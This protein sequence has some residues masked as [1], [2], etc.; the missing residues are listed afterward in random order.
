MRRVEGDGKDGGRGRTI[1]AL[2]VDVADGE[3]VV[4]IQRTERTQ[5]EAIGGKVAG[6]DALAADVPH[7]FS[8]H[9]RM[10]HGH[11]EPGEGPR[12]ILAFADFYARGG[13][14]VVRVGECRTSGRR[15]EVPFDAKGRRI[16]RAELMFTKDGADVKWDKRYWETKDIAEFDPA[17]GRVVTEL[18]EG[19]FAWIVN[20]TT[21]DGL[22]FS[23]KYSEAEQP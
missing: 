11:G 1:S 3:E 15:I 5:H 22:V 6:L 19:A 13:L 8:T 4:R 21:D 10:V 23:T 16:V 18:P 20:F 17:S 2:R 7:A 12:E 14:D 9:L